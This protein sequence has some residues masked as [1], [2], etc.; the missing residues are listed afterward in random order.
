MSAFVL[1]LCSATGLLTGVITR[2]VASAAPAN[3]PALAQATATPTTAPPTA[4][5]TSIP[6]NTPGSSNQFAVSISV[7]GQAHPGQGIAI[8]GSISKAGAP[9]A[10]ARCTL[11]AEAGFDPLLQT[12]PDETTTDATGKCSW[13]ITLPEQTA[14][15]SYRIRVDGYTAQYHAWSFATVRVS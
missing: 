13:S 15:G 8:N 2:E 7:A 6:T 12:W 14:P 11:G 9:V 1:A 5:A 10:G 4:T 3:T